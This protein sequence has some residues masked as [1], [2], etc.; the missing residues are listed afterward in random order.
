MSGPRN[1][2]LP[3]RLAVAIDR[4]FDRLGPVARPLEV[5]QRWADAVGPTVARNAWPARVRRD[6]TL[7]VHTSSSVWAHELTQ[8]GDE[9]RDRLAPE[10]PA[11]LQFVV[12]AIPDP[13]P[14]SPPKPAGPPDLRREAT[15]AELR[16]AGQIASEIEDPAL[17]EAAS[18]AIAATLARS[19][20]ARAV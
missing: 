8:L 20:S 12:G 1:W 9:I 15:P 6:G 16:E 5:T 2:A 10:A 14:D 17:R 19:R 4:E 18:Q 13:G 11:G 7:V 3:K